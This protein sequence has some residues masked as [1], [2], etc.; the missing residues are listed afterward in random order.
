MHFLNKLSYAMK[1]NDFRPLN[2]RASTPSGLAGIRATRKSSFQG[3]VSL[4]FHVVGMYACMPLGLALRAIHFPSLYA[5]RNLSVICSVKYLPGP[6]KLRTAVTEIRFAALNRP[7]DVLTILSVTGKC[8]LEAR[9]YLK[10]AR[11]CYS[12]SDCEIRS[13]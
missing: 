5:F 3:V 10:S 12:A 4:N 8:L 1:M 11:S 7:K 9:P 6:G 13:A 2:P